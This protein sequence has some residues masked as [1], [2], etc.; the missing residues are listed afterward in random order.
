MNEHTAALR[1][2]WEEFRLYPP[3]RL[4]E[5]WRR[6]AYAG[7]SPSAAERLAWGYRFARSRTLDARRA[8]RP[9]PLPAWDA[10]NR[11][12]EYALNGES[13][14]PP[15]GGA[16][17]APFKSGASCLRWT[18]NPEDN[19]L[20][21]V[22]YADEIGRK[23]G[24]W[25]TFEASG[26]YLEPDG[27]GGETARGVVYQLP[28]RDGR[29]VYVAG[30]QTSYDK[31]GAALQFGLL[32]YGEPGGSESF[33][34]ADDALDAARDAYGMAESYAEEARDYSEASGARLEF[35]EKREEART[36]AREGIELARELKRGGNSEVARRAMAE[37]LDGI[38]GEVRE[39]FARRR[40]LES[41]YSNAQ[42]WRDSQ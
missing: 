41:I 27:V 38:R 22:G 30:V 10:L 3:E 23:A 13:K 35:N 7:G 1:K 42:G 24:N 6:P 5:A 36:L 12:R 4:R 2:R 28:A 16:F 8:A 37:R 18:E 21:F 34:V 19:G 9:S 26:F 11:A 14:F 39:A 17:G 33:G 40:E 20:R 29:A 32:Y 15:H 25:R 31:T